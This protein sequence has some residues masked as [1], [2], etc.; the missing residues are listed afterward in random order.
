MSV[1]ALV[2]SDYYLLVSSL[3]ISDYYLPVCLNSSD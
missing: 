3:V 2:I 1:S